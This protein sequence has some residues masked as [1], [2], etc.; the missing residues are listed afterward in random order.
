MLTFLV[1][2]KEDKIKEY[3]QSDPENL[4]LVGKISFQIQLPR[5]LVAVFTDGSEKRQDL[6]RVKLQ[7]PPGRLV[8]SSGISC[9]S[10]LYNERS[11]CIHRTGHCVYCGGFSLS[12]K[13][14]SNS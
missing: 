5:P 6:E 3:L 7:K 1:Q 2:D 14:I 12:Q 9:T 13:I 8:Q 11:P 10:E 4:S